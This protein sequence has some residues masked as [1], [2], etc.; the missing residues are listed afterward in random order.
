MI[1][2][3]IF[4]VLK[5]KYNT[6]LTVLTELFDYVEPYEEPYAPLTGAKRMS[7]CVRSRVR[8]LKLGKHLL[9][10]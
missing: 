3:H 7:E 5:K 2:H 9:A 10:L 1:N 6:V 8:G 4:F